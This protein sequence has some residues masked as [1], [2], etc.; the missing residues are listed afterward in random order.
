MAALTAQ[1]VSAQ[2]SGQNL[3]INVTYY[4]ATDTG[5]TTPLGSNTVTVPASLSASNIQK[6]IVASGQDFRNS[7]NLIATYQGT[8]VNIP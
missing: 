4:L 7:Y 8:T 2:P 6:Q 5:L 1:V 3:V